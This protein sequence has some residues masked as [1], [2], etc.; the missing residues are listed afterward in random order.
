[1]LLSEAFTEYVQIFVKPYQ[2]SGTVRSFEC[3]K[4]SFINYKD[5]ILD[6]L[7]QEYVLQWQTTNIESGVSP[8]TIRGYT[9]KLRKVLRHFRAKGEN[10]LSP[11][12]VYSPR[13]IEKNPEYL[14]AKEVKQL[15][16]EA[17][18]KRHGRSKISRYRTAAIIS[19]LY[20]TGLRISE[21]C[22]LDIEHI[23]TPE[24]AIIGKYGRH[25]IVYLDPRT[26]YLIKEYL[27]LRADEH[28]A[29]FLSGYGHRLDPNKVRETFRCLS[30]FYGKQVH[31]HMLRHSYATNLMSNGGHIF[32]VKE[33]MG[34]SSIQSTSRYLHVTNP[35][36]KEAYTKYHSV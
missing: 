10:C 33:L 7:T 18:K 35:E 15:I 28:P 6:E 1:M 34:H 4:K 11:D 17:L 20:S 23:K 30:K 3:A 29:L 2:A 9:E 16:D 24:V 22:K 36:L 19:I 12:L 13:K 32:K 31:P 5:I 25:R 27:S 21:M 26:Q 8:N 14:T